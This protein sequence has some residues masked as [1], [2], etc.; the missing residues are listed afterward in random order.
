MLSAVLK[1]GVDSDV[2]NCSALKTIIGHTG[3]ENL[4]C[5]SVPVGPEDREPLVL[6]TRNSI[7][8]AV[9]VLLGADEEA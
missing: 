7:F 5:V 8:V 4:H 3:L 9:L 1:H 6:Q 2:S